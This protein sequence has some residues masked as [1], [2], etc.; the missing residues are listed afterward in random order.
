M[1]VVSDLQTTMNTRDEDIFNTNNNS[2][3]LHA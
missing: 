2:Q 1:L 3:T